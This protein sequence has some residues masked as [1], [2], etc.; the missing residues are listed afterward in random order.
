M[1]DI[2]FYINSDSGV[3]EMVL[4]RPYCQNGKTQ[5][6]VE[7]QEA[8]RAEEQGLSSPCSVP[9]GLPLVYWWGLLPKMASLLR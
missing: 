8:E 9:H 7:I 5:G 2:P 6:K 3:Q 4:K 1:R